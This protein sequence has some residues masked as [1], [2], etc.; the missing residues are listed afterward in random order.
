MVSLFFAESRLNRRD[1]YLMIAS[2]YI[3]ALTLSAPPLFDDD[4]FQLEPFRLA[5]SINWVNLPTVY[6]ATLMTLGYV[7]PLLCMLFCYTQ[8]VNS[9]IEVQQNVVRTHTRFDVHLAKVSECLYILL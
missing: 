4:G 8:M 2:T 6:F 9:V 7:L 1:V 5:C 3:Y